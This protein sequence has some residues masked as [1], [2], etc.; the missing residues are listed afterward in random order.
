MH[1]HVLATMKLLL[2]N[3]LADKCPQ[4]CVDAGFITNQVATRIFMSI[5]MWIGCRFIK[6]APKQ[7]C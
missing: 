5:I 3:Q 6:Q 1:V 2:K 4:S 7:L